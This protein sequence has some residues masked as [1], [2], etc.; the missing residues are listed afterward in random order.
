MFRTFQVHLEGVSPLLLSNCANSDPLGDAQRR[1]EHYSSKHK[2]SEDDHRHLRTLDWLYSVY[3][4]TEGQVMVDEGENQLAFDGYAD[5]YLPSSNFQRCLRNAATRWKLGKATLQAISV[6]NDPPLQFDG[7]KDA[8]AMFNSRFPKYQLASFVKRGQKGVWINRCI[9]PGWEV[10]YTL[11]LDDEVIE[12]D[13]FRRIINAAG[14]GEGLGTWRP[15][16]GRFVCTSIE[17]L[18]EC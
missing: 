12:V 6:T 13:Q 14:K 5:P 2:K 18:E 7:P 17:E 16:Y 10:D 8:V 11:T 1:K 4:M 3:W 15:R 9:I